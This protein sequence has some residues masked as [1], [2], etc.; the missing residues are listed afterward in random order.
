MAIIQTVNFGQ[1]CQAFVDM[2][3]KEQFSYKGL[4][5][6][7][8]YLEEL[9][10]DIGGPIELDVIALCC[11]YEESDYLDIADYYGI[12]LSEFDGDESEEF[13]IVLDYLENSTSVC[14][15]DE[16]TGNIVYALF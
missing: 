15:Y 2:G 14:G 5:I 8:N 13:K 12:D 7:F 16:E 4:E 1:F 10:N 6:L 3:R 9:A 11:D